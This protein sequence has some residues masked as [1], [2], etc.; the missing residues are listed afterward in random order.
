MNAKEEL[1]KRLV[2]MVSGDEKLTFD[3]KNIDLKDKTNQ[4]QSEE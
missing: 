3:E 2:A 1:A 4:R